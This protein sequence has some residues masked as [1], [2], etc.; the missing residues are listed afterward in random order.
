MDMRVITYRRIDYDEK[1]PNSRTAPLSV[2]INDVVGL[3][4]CAIIPPFEILNK[5]FLSGGE[6]NPLMDADW[7]PFEISLEEYDDLCVEME[8]LEPTEIGSVA[9]YA[10]VKVKRAK[11]FDS[12]RDEG[13]WSQAVSSKYEAEFLENLTAGV[14]TEQNTIVEEPNNCEKG[15]GPPNFRK[16]ESA[17]FDLASQAIDTFFSQSPKTFY[18]FGIDCNATYGD[19]LLCANTQDDFNRTAEYYVENWDYSDARLT[20]LK[21]NF[22]DWKYQ[23]FNID[24]P[25]WNQGWK[26]SAI[27]IEAYVHHEYTSDEDSERFLEQLLESFTAVLIR[28]ERSGVL[29]I[30]KKDPGFYIQIYDHDENPEA[31]DKRLAIVR[32]RGAELSETIGK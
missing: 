20:S 29:D 1:R 15:P 24:Y 14:S 21:R 17:L 25:F 31:G 5:R 13:E 6:C 28:L 26:K 10:F 23:G 27:E 32:K 2:F 3:L 7:H 4:E 30:I 12:I 22:G 16:L 19:V 11:E 8:K 18:A 9:R